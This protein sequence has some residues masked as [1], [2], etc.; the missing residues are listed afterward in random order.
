[1]RMRAMRLETDV[2]VAALCGDPATSLLNYGC[3]SSQREK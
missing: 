2:A 3:A 1:M